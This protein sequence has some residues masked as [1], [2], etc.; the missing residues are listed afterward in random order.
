M[1]LKDIEKEL[2]KALG[3]GTIMNLSD[4]EAVKDGLSSG[5]HMLNYALSGNPLVG[6]RWGRIVE[7]F[8]P[9]ASGKTT[10]ALHAIK[11]AQRASIPC[12]IIDAEHTLD[13]EYAEK[14][15]VNFEHCSVSQPD[16]GE[17][18]IDTIIKMIEADYKL[19]V[20]DSV[21]ALVPRAELEGEPGD[22]HMGKHA[23][24]MSQAMKMIVGRASRAGCTIIFLNQIRSSMAMMGNPE[25]TSG[26]MALG[27]YASYRVEI[28]AP[29]S[30]A[31]SEKSLGE[32]TTETGI[33]TKITVKKNKVFPPYRKAE[34]VINYGEGI[35]VYKD[36]GKFLSIGK[37][38]VQVGDKEYTPKFSTKEVKGNRRII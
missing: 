24:L 31:L 21:A 17:K 22:S 2:N 29:R 25:T 15:G 14:I 12:A 8:G 7:I 6:Y 10:F 33:L 16:Y 1:N 30:G 26:G 28:R 34:V 9:H 3:E 18:A 37:D 27:F 23:K 38:K 36:L 19:I 4:T 35:D 5:S 13:I 32:G 20:V 11:E